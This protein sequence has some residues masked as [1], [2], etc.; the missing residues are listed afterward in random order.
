MMDRLAYALYG[1]VAGVLRV[2]PLSVGY[3][4][5]WWLGT[6]AWHV[7]PPYRRLVRA[8]LCIAFGGEK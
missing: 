2:L 6:M 7:A 5:G 3:R 8:N 4:L 1:L